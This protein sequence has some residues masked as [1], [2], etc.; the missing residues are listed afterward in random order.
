MFVLRAGS[1]PVLMGREQNIKRKSIAMGT[2]IYLHL[3][4][5]RVYREKVAPAFQV[6]LRK[7]NSEPL[8]SLLKECSQILAADKQ[9]AKRLLWDMESCKED[10]GI[11]EG[12]VYYSPDDGE[13]SNQGER[14]KT[15]KVRRDYARDLL[16]SNILQ[17]VCVPRDSE[18]NPVQ[19][20]GRSQIIP[21]LYKHSQ[22]IK[23]LFTSVRMVRGGELE[24]PIGESSE[25][26]TKEDIK[27]FQEAL[28]TVPLPED[29]DLS[30]QYRNLRLLLKSAIENPD[31][32]LILSVM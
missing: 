31:L 14:K 10:I 23:D 2:D 9:L 26:F 29:T 3:F 16:I 8:V 17:V 28:L 1:D 24:L 7:D 12:T 4:N 22:W 25:I 11:L 21:H 13:S 5:M 27:E 20:M 19:N 30:K 6:F 18:L 32:T 15:H